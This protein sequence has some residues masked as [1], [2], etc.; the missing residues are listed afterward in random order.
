MLVRVDWTQHEIPL[1]FTENDSPRMESTVI[2]KWRE[3]MVVCRKSTVDDEDDASFVLHMS[4]TRVIPLMERDRTSQRVSHSIALQ[5]KVTRINM[6]SSLDKSI[7]LWHSWKKGTRIYILRPRS[8]ANAVEWYTFLNTL[9]GWRRPERLDIHVPDLNIILNLDKPFQTTRR[10]QDQV[11]SS[12]VSAKSSAVQE[13]SQTAVAHDIIRRCVSMLSASPMSDNLKMWLAS[14][15]KIGL[16][17]R[18][19]DRLEWIYGVNAE[20]MYGSMAM[21]TT[22]D[23]ELR[24]EE[25]YP[26]RA[27]GSDSDHKATE[28]PAA[29]E[30]FL[31]RLTSQKGR[32]SRMGKSFFKRLYFSSHDHYL[33]FSL[34]GKAVPPKPPKFTDLHHLKSVP[35]AAK[36]AE[37]IPLIYA[38]NPYPL[39]EGRITWL[40]ADSTTEKQHKDEVAEA[41]AARKLQNLQDSQGFMLGR[42]GPKGWA[43]GCPR[44][45]RRDSGQRELGDG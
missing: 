11:L 24:L 16:A 30:G 8:S 34:P 29:V 19:Y 28:E 4:K 39:T 5:K 42:T 2:E 6:F 1:G 22:H 13:A 20:R 7:V 36:L 37:K 23:L 26:T 18:R 14:G 43:F 40:A 45:Q 32:H 38:V 25:H 31:V 3:Y 12:N 9:L 41:E 15:T 21:Q 35:K 33:C 27:G 17:W 10:P 44:S